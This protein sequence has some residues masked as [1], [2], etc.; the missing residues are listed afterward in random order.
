MTA[1][2]R[3]SAHRSR[4]TALLVAASSIATLV[5]ATLIALFNQWVQSYD[6][7]YFPA[8]ESSRAATYPAGFLGEGWAL[9][10]G[11]AVALAVAIVLWLQLLPHFVSGPISVWLALSAGF[12]VPVSLYLSPTVALPFII[13]AL[14]AVCVA[15]LRRSA[16]T[17]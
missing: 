2:Q 8:V 11:I 7:I 14:A 15:L 5:S 16:Q 4:R 6:R 1:I 10:L 17:A 13:S 12:A 9:A 3:S